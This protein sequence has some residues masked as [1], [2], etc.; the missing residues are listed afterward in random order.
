MNLQL[1]Y[2]LGHCTSVAQRFEVSL[3]EAKDFLS[4]N[5]KNIS[6][7]QNHKVIVDR[8]KMKFASSFEYLESMCNRDNLFYVKAD[9]PSDEIYERAIGTQN[10]YLTISDRVKDLIERMINEE[11]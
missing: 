1:D 2:Q 3:Q 7:N 9:I 6:S 10:T 5:R 11:I 8:M 4:K